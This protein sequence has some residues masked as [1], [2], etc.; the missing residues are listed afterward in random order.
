MNKVILF[1][2][3]VI[4]FSCSSV[5]N[6]EK[7]NPAYLGFYEYQSDDKAENHYIIIDTLNNEYKSFY[8]GTEDGSGHGVFFYSSKLEDLIINNQEINFKIKER[9][10]FNRTRFR[11][12]KNRNVKKDSS[13]GFSRSELNYKG[14]FTEKGIEL[15]CSSEFDNCWN[16]NMFFTKISG[17]KR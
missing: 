6:R 7:I 17:M 14:S 5:S 2:I 9:E 3:G 11:I 4:L 12:V 16:D 10:L 1:V 15:K 13:I 8:Y